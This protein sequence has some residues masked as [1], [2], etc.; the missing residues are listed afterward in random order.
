MNN[1]EKANHSVN[2]LS[3]SAHSRSQPSSQL[4][5]AFQHLGQLHNSQPDPTDGL[6]CEENVRTKDE[7][8][9]EVM[10]T[11]REKRREDEQKKAIP[12]RAQTA[13][14]TLSWKAASFKQI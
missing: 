7:K 10:D 8:M 3:H 12:G 1:K 14:V 11:P 6:T 4:P 5:R 9:E 13:T 2:Y